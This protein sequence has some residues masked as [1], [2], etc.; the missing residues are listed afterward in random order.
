[1]PVATSTNP[2]RSGVLGGLHI[3]LEEGGRVIARSVVETGD[4][5]ITE[6]LQCDSRVGACGV[7]G[8]GPRRSG[9][10]TY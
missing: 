10:T 7:R 2:G 1:M 5:S 9:S 8:G 6:V 3:G 4:A